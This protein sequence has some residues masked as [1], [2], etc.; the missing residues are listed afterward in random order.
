MLSAAAVPF[1]LNSRYS[2]SAAPS[3][4]VAADINGDGK[5]DALFAETGSSAVGVALGDGRDRAAADNS[6]GSENLD[7][8]ADA[9]DWLSGLMNFAHH[10]EQVL[11]VADIFGRAAARDECTGEVGSAG[12]AISASSSLVASSVSSSARISSENGA[13]QP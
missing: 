3:S 10:A 2:V 4:V 6:G 5:P 1:Q 13:S 8:V 11:V 9:G 7:A 12:V